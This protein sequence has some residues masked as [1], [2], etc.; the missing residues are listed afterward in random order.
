MKFMQNKTTISPEAAAIVRPEWDAMKQT[1]ADIGETIYPTFEKDQVYTIITISEWM[2]HT[3]KRQVKATGIM[4]NGRPVFKENKRGT[5]K[6][7]TLPTLFAKGTI[8]LHA[9]NDLTVDSEVTSAPSVNGFT[10]T[11]TRGNA[12]FNFV[13]TADNIKFAMIGNL[14]PNFDQYDRVLAINPEKPFDDG[15]ETI[16]FDSGPT[17]HAVVERIRA[18]VTSETTTV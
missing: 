5:R 15:N 9:S 13:G 12:C 10:S 7:F 2:A 3:V 18:R 16:V 11:I 6:M 8:I 17:Q 14:N 4:S 1:I